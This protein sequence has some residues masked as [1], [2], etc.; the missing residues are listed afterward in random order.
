MA[1]QVYILESDK[2]L[3][4]KINRHELRVVYHNG[5]DKLLIR[6]SNIKSLNKA[7][8]N[9]CERL[10]IPLEVSVQKVTRFI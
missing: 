2:P 10:G 5:E 1:A 4:G 7:G 9:W 8:L 6:G 3:P